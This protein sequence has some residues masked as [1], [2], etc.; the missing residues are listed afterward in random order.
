MSLSIS[1]H[2]NSIKDNDIYAKEDGSGGVI[3]AFSEG[4]DAILETCE[5][6]TKTLLGE[7]TYNTTQGVDYFNLAFV[8]TPNLILLEVALRRQIQTVEGVRSIREF[9]IQVKQGDDERTSNIVYHAVI[10]TEQ[11][12]G[13]ING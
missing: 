5:R 13:E 3:L 12:I 11:G 8:D 7:L 1:I 2:K 10:L 4:I 6:K 9:T